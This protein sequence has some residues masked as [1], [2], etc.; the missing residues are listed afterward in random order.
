MSSDVKTALTSLVS[1][2]MAAA[3]LLVVAGSAASTAERWL[4]EGAAGAESGTKAEA[5]PPASSN[6][7]LANFIV[8]PLYGRSSS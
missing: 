7:R 3:P 6:N 8:Y 2:E 4:V 5:D 1:P